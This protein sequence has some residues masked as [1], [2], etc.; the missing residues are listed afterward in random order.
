[1]A[2]LIGLKHAADDYLETSQKQI[3]FAWSQTQ[4]LASFLIRT[5]NRKK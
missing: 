4:L 5:K 3:L 2:K 1:M